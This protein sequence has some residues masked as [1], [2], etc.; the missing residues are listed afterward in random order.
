MMSFTQHMH[1]CGAV[2]QTSFAENWKPPSPQGLPGGVASHWLQT[3]SRQVTARACLVRLWSWSFTT[4]PWDQR[5]QPLWG[6]WW[7]W[8]ACSVCSSDAYTWIW[9]SAFGCMMLQRMML[10]GGRS[11]EDTRSIGPLPRP[12]DSQLGHK[13]NLAERCT[14]ALVWH[15]CSRA[16]I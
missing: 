9:S 15:C 6:A 14:A 16:N 13:R 7:S 5:G 10:M 3:S 12:S 8:G 11:P 4:F 1:R 2:A